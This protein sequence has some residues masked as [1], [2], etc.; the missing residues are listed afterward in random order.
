MSRPPELLEGRRF[1]VAAGHPAAAQAAAS[2]AER[3]GSLADSAIAASA[4]L[5][6][7][8]PHATSL[9][10]DFLALIRAEDGSIEGLD[11]AGVAPAAVD[12]VKFDAIPKKGPR[13]SVVPGIV[14]GWAML[15]ARHGRLDWASLFAPAIRLASAG[16]PLSASVHEFIVEERA[17][18]EADA[19][20]RERFLPAGEPLAAGSLLVQTAL[21]RTLAAVASGGE[22]A[23]YDGDIGR[24]LCG[25]IG[26]NGGLLTQDDL[27]SY[28]ARPVVP[29]EGTYRGA[30]CTVMP[31]S[32]YGL[33]LLLQLAGLESAQ[34]DAIARDAALRFG[35]QR[36]VMRA[37][38]A[39]GRPLLADGLDAA[40]RRQLAGLREQVRIES[41][42]SDESVPRE[43]QGGTAC[44][45]LADAQGNAITLVQS[46]FNPFGA[47]VL[48]PA[49][50]ILMNNRLSGF[51]LEPMSA[52]HVRAGRRPAHTLCPVML[53]DADGRLVAFAS[54]GGISQTVTGT[55][56]VCNL[57]DRGMDLA[58]A[59]GEP[60]WSLSRSREVLVEPDFAPG[61]DGARTVHD[62]YAFGSIK[63]VSRSPDGS[64]KAAADTR[65]SAAALA[66]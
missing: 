66:L 24:A 38:F 65:R 5:C 10:G 48:D 63:A 56:F 42:R 4:V 15:H 57:V 23:F 27:R 36:R 35:L 59:I 55:Q 31:P 22:A 26:A 3:G 47:A 61:T 21:A 6:V 28:V 62:P 25:Y 43:S 16:L 52:N 53:S 8:L 30:R 1:A 34:G 37:A 19:G 45:A 17:A 51:D 58:A 20:C 33:L 7:A 60:R 41:G 29:I 49:T 9:G 11:A 44:V 32:S 54:P 40:A 39:A 46:V 2:M 50:G 18:L 14:R 64:L 12:R 13:A